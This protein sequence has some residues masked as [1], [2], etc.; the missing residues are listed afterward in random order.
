[1][2]KDSVL[3]ADFHVINEKN[4]LRTPIR[5]GTTGS[6]KGIRDGG[7]FVK[8][9]E[10]VMIECF[11]KDLPER[12]VADISNLEL[13]DQILVKDLHFGKGVE[14]LTDPEEVIGT[15]RFIKEEIEEEEVDTEIE[16]DEET[17]GE[18]DEEADAATAE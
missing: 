4:K 13:Q 11:P 9:I 8:G 12:I 17:D 1:I 10:T 3:H 14:V 7:V 15:V 2:I 18:T 16:T 6:P 5:V